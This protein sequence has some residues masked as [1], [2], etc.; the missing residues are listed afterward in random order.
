MFD[1]SPALIWFLVG[2]GFILA[3]LAMPGLILIFFG[4]G[5]WVASLFT[6]LFG[7]ELEWQ[8]AVFLAASLA[9]LF[10]LRKYFTR[11]FG[12]RRK[13]GADR[14]LDDRVIGKPAE[15]TAD[16]GAHSAGE[17]KFR[18]SFWRAVSDTPLAAGEA[19]IIIGA[20]TEDK[21]TYRVKP[22]GDSK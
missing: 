21:L 6:L 10:T 12:G 14:E 16:I 22:A 4:M 15:V 20:E 8:L 2:V 7:P 1:L 3:E 18:G 13:A 17:I 5:C 9:L 11:T 19:V